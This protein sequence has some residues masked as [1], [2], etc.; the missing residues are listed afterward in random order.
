MT[1]KNYEALAGRINLLV[2]SH[3]LMKELAKE[4]TATPDKLI[5]HYDLIIRETIEFIMDDLE[6]DNHRFD[7]N[8]FL[9]ACHKEPQV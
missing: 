5:R 6:A 1:K 9:I 2:R 8:K 7:R 4:P 3:K